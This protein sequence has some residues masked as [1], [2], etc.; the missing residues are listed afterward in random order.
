LTV[1]EDHNAVIIYIGKVFSIVLHLRN[2]KQPNNSLFYT[3]KH[4]QVL[5]CSRLL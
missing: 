2:G 5:F 4:S 1:V 3:V